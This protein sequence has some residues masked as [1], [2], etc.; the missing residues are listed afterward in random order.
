M[1]TLHVIVVLS[2]LWLS[3]YALATPPVMP[4]DEVEVGMLGNGLTVF[5]GTEIESFDVEIIGKLQNI[6]PDRNMILALCSGGPLART[7]VI[8]GM[9]GSP[10]MIDGKLIGA[11][12]Y[13][14]GFSTEAIA[15][16][17]PIEEMLAIP[18]GEANRR[19]QRSAHGPEGAL[20]SGL[21]HDP[22]RLE[23]FLSSRLRS[24]LG[25][26][27][28]APARTIPLAVSGIGPRAF[29]RMMPELSA[30]GF[31][32]VQAGAARDAG[33][34][35]L[36]TPSL[37]P[38]SAIG[39]KL[40][41]G[42][43]EMTAG[44]TVTL[45]DEDL[46][47]AFGHPFIGLGVVDLPMSAARVDALLPSLHI[48]TK[49]ITPLGE[50]GSLRQDRSTGILGRIGV[51]PSMIPVVFRF[52][53]A[54]REVKTYRF[55]IADDP[56]L[57]PVLLYLSLSGIMSGKE[58]PLGTSTVSLSDGSVI[59]L[60]NA[61]DVRLDNLF[62]GVGA[63]RDGGLLPAY[64]LHLLMNNSWI[65][66]EISSIN[67]LLAYEEHPRT[68][69]IKRATLNRHHARPGDL[70][71]ATVVIQP[72]RGPDQILETEIRIPEE[73]LPGQLTIHIGSAESLDRI[74]DSAE[75]VLPQNMSQLI[76]LINQIRRNDRIYIMALR[77]DSGVLLD[78]QRLPN[79]PP[80]VAQVLTQ[81][82][83]RGNYPRVRRRMVF[84]DRIVT[85]Y[86]I[87]GAIK[88]S[89]LLESP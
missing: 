4:F 31:L 86:A 9:S 83:S 66:S 81:T 13:S 55:D 63:F 7:G 56:L 19:Q 43:V 20:T 72:F 69:Q 24:L 27:E 22:D 16:I 58:S 14:W 84:E 79:L 71:T 88:L 25:N 28:A 21:L 17:T 35:A 15:G 67:L 52:T 48:S 82:D 23:Q 30:A 54:D 57:S 51:E 3:S 42:A 64:V 1:K 26:S 34:A 5:T 44:G 39:I 59:K 89:L 47:L 87:G 65:Q 38:G 75:R 68:A 53:G 18:T 2:M 77:E 76:G 62:A 29:Q 49:I 46:V 6:G 78:G 32:P 12:A 80:S 37:E 74:E 85:D 40:V 8:A 60:N 33:G 36:P 73:A 45:V 41:R 70:V 61:E 10:V 11:L 50:V